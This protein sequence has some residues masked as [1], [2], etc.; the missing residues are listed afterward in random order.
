MLI[1]ASGFPLPVDV[2]ASAREAFEGLH[3]EEQELV[4]GLLA[5]ALGNLS[6]QL[7]NAMSDVQQANEQQL[8]DLTAAIEAAEA[9]TGRRGRK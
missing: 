5:R 8:K 2:P 3:G 6:L 9:D 4:S 7:D 1:Q